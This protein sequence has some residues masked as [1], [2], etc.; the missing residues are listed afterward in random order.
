MRV[1]VLGG[2][3][4]VGRAV[5]EELA[6][7]RHDVLV[8]HRGEQE[9]DDLPEVE[10]LHMTREELAARPQAAQG[11][12]PDAVVDT[13]ALNRA[14]AEAGLRG[15]PGELPRVVVSSGDVYRAYGSLQAGTITD[16]VPLSESA[17][18]RAERYPYAG[19]PP[20]AT[21]GV[22]PDRYEKLDVEEVYRAA[23]AT[24][25][26]LGFVYGERDYQRR[27]EFIL[28]RVRAGRARIPVGP[29]SWIVSRTYVR[30]A[31]RAARLALE[32]GLRGETFNVC[33]AAGTPVRL[34]AEQI[35]EAAGLRADRLVT[36]PAE[37]LPPDLWP[38]G[39]AGQ[40]LFLDSRR[41]REILGWQGTAAEE[42]V[43]TSVRWHLAHP[44]PAETDAFELD[45][46]A[47]ATHEASL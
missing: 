41:A 36:V 1:V 10:H 14:D 47:L 20:E 6:A 11:F 46:Q 26:R 27:E 22:D 19:Q 3:R 44:P 9:P 8:I 23:G 16:A 35:V 45:D 15:V 39:L 32:R 4:F 12:R 28:R 7:H 31:A 43:R 40:H 5:V 37:R 42:A 25:L 30:D 29:G 33:E 38:T 2:T 13:F 18:L 24:V 17:P 21:L 34:W